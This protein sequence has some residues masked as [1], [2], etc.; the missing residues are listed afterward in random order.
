MTTFDQAIRLIA[1]QEM[2]ES[3]HQLI[4]T[5]QESTY[6]WAN[7]NLILTRH[8]LIETD[9]MLDKKLEEIDVRNF[10]I[11][12][13]G[14]VNEM[15]NHY[16][17]RLDTLKKMFRQEDIGLLLNS[18]RTLDGDYRM[19]AFLEISVKVFENLDKIRNQFSEFELKQISFFRHKFCHSMLTN[20]SV[21]I[22]KKKKITQIEKEKTIR[23]IAETDE[24]E[25]MVIF[26]EKLLS[27]R[28]EVKSTEKLIQSMQ[29]V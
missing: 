22:S 9:M 3:E 8:W 23:E 25:S 1:E 14:I 13:N 15:F 6:F 17:A 21:K 4:G 5:F 7:K 29:F 10:Y 19:R 20:L 2:P 26:H 18:I 11:K 16:E 24:L 12:L 28:D 27:K